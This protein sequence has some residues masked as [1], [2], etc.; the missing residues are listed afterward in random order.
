MQPGSPVGGCGKTRWFIAFPAR[1]RYAL[2]LRVSGY[3]LHLRLH[4]RCR[5]ARH[6]LLHGEEIRLEATWRSR[7][8]D[9]IAA[10]RSCRNTLLDL[11][12]TI[13]SPTQM[14]RD[15]VRSTTSNS[16]NW[17]YRRKSCPIRRWK[18]T[19]GTKDSPDRFPACSTCAARIAESPFPNKRRPVCP[20]VPA[21]SVIK[22][23]AVSVVSG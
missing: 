5:F 4:R 15:K 14:A 3:A 22:S 11:C 16:E 18:R 19:P 6:L 23:S 7:L 9:G 20:A 2:S 12:R 10:C 17:Y 21:P 13:S 8:F 1:E